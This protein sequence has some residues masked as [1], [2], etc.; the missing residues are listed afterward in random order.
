MSELPAPDEYYYPTDN[1]A[2][3]IDIDTI[4]KKVANG[5]N[6]GIRIVAQKNI[7]IKASKNR[8]KGK[9]LQSSQEQSN[10]NESAG[11]SKSTEDSSAT[12]KSS[13]DAAS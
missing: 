7:P 4:F 1:Q 6:S 13:T 9:P 2:N 5:N 11:Q 8:K 12:T 3:E 10:S